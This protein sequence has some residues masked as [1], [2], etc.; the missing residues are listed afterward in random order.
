MY[1]PPESVDDIL[2]FIVKNSGKDSKI[3]FDYYPESIV[4]GTWRT[5]LPYGRAIEGF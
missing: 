4:D 5:L 3:I 2:F 1:L